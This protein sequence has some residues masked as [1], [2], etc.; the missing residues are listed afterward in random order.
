M[1]QNIRPRE[2]LIKQGA[3]A[4][5]DAELL[6]IFLRT[7][8]NGRNAVELASDLLQY[9]GGLAK[10]NLATQSQVC[11][12]KGIGDAKYAQFK[13]SIELAKRCLITD[14]E[15][16]AISATDSTTVKNYILH[17]LTHHKE[18]VFAALFLD[19]K[20]RLIAFEKLFFGTIN[21]ATV[22]PR[23][24]IRKAIEHNAA[25]II[26]THNHPSGCLT[27]SQADKQLTKELKSLLNLV[28]VRLLDHIIIGAGSSL[29]MVEEAMHYP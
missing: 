23:T 17:Q 8:C 10:L 19:N 21:S 14:M 4:L 15:N 26:I 9:F 29:S 5:S 20:N 25:A 28:D 11:S 3:K 13:A 1:P 27:P 18:E 7:G 16:N 24:I 12:Q 22:Y 6:A 2:R